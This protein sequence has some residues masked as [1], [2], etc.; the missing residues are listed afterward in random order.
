MLR[1]GW[2]SALPL[3]QLPG[4][5]ALL[6]R[7]ELAGLP[8]AI[9]ARAAREAVSHARERLRAG[10]PASA[11]LAAAVAADA[12]RRA[13]LLRGR[14]LRRVINATGIVLHTN[15]GRAP[16]A[17]DAVQAVQDVAR[18]YSNTELDLASG[19][20]GGRLA[21]IAP[22]LTELTGAEAAIA[23]NN[24]AAGV[25]LALTALARDAE[26]IVSRGE[27]VEIGGSF[28]VPD[29]I[30][31][32]GARLVEVGTTN[33]TRV[34]DY[35][36]AIT[37]RT[38]LLLRV[39]PSNFRQVGFVE[40][41]ER[42]ALAALARERGLP[43]IDDLGSGALGPPIPWPAPDAGQAWV[44]SE[45][46]DRAIAEG[47]DL[48]CFSCDKL[49]GGPQ[50]GVIAGRADL[51]ERCRTHPLYRALRIDKLVLAA[52]EATLLMYREGRADEVPARALL[53]RSP[54]QC[55]D[56]AEV[57]AARIPGAVV[58]QDVSYSGGGALPGQALP[59]AV[60]ALRLPAPDAVATRLREMNPPII[61]RVS[62]DAVLIDPR[63]LLRGDADLLVAALASIAATGQ[64]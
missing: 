48:V 19:R 3:R 22:L 40:R 51:V 36:R 47:A 41:P 6:L 2:R 31:S 53:G 10:A 57:L 38:A 58:E 7:P 24:N 13:S 34:A 43:L 12:A 59:T 32:G 20:R 9:A 50:A 17:E 28:R 18:G 25:L 4:V 8:H 15:L 26:V 56:L 60:V 39:H 14:K 11:D 16:L 46:V 54:G 37:P 44:D 61:T 49:L 35:A 63:T 29:V 21:G 1:G 55:R 27:L 33:R 42:A 5:S 23:V 30:A 62:R 52:L 45:P 64:D